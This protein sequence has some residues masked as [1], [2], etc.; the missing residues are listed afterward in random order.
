MNTT[1]RHTIALAAALV[2]LPALPAF[3]ETTSF[4]SLALPTAAL[5]LSGAP[6][7]AMPSA[8]LAIL[9]APVPD[10]QLA[11]VHYRPRR[12]TGGGRRL[13]SES[14]TQIHLGFFDPEGDA[15]RQFLLGVRGGPM[16]DPHVQL[17]VSVDWAHMADNVSTGGNKSLFPNGIP[18]TTKT[19]LSRYSSDLF[20]IIGFVQ[21]SGDDKMSVIPYFGIGGGYEVMNLTADNYVTGA[22]FDA[23]Y[24]GWGWQAWGG[25]AFPLSGRARVNGELFVNTAELNRDV[26][27]SALGSTYRETVTANGVGMRLGIAWGF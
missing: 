7:F 23:T 13:D 4:P 25:A 6:V 15:S 27:D 19:D 24:G 22:T 8:D 18:I 10:V 12:S 16:I 2:V 9:H 11:G 21:V 20:P 17:G 26:Y 1:L 3:A 14:V 5:E